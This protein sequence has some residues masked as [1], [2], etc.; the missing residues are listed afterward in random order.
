MQGDQDFKRN[1]R[2][3]SKVMWFCRRHV[4]WNRL[5]KT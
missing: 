1:A 5:R 3:L 4:K 2:K